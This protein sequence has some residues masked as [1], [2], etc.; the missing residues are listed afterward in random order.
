MAY[1]ATETLAA[2]NLL[3]ACSYPLI[4][5]T[6]TIK[7]GAGKLKRGTVVG[8]G[9]T[10]PANPDAT[11]PTPEV[12]DTSGKLVIAPRGDLAFGVLA[13]DVDATSADVKASIIICGAVQA[14]ELTVVSGS[15]AADFFD[16]LRRIG[17][18]SI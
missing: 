8:T 7:S 15:T 11:P 14:S 2:D 9:I 13:E 12:L 4:Y 17:I 3:A 16:G 6:G 18:F 10:T 1:Q 5:Q